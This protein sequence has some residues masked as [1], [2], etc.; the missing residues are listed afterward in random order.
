MMPVDFDSALSFNSRI[1]PSF[2]GAKM[3]AVLPHPL[4]KI[5]IG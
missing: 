4:T 2:I 1:F 5:C 3:F